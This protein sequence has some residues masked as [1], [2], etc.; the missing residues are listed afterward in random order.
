MVQI[1]DDVWESLCDLRPQFFLMLVIAVLLL[2]VSIVTF[3][4]V[5]PNSAAAV[6]IRVDL[7]IFTVVLIPIT[8]IL[9][10]CRKHEQSEEFEGF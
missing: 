9:Y 3:P 10:R 4:F 7:V 2:F 5:D 8:Y 1:P 6:L